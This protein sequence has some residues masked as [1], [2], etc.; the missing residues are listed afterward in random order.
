M[1]KE[2]SATQRKKSTK[3]SRKTTAKLSTSAKR[4]QKEL[5]EIT[6]NP[7]LTTDYINTQREILHP[8]HSPVIC[9]C[10]R[11]VDGQHS[12]SPCAGKQGASCPSHIRGRYKTSTSSPAMVELA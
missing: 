1:K 8:G 6:L 3:L 10:H 5:A 11:R 7:L 12:D 4:I 9:P 2:P